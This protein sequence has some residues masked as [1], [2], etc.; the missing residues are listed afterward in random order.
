MPKTIISIDR[1]RTP[2]NQPEP[3]IVNRWHPDTPM[4]AHVKPGE[5]F[6]IETFSWDGAQIGNNDSANDVRDCNLL[7]CHHLSGAVSVKAASGA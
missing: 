7:P 3:V 6:R 5:D 1:S 2:A 4:Y